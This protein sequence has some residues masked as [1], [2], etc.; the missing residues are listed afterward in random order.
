MQGCGELMQVVASIDAVGG[1][2]RCGGGSVD[3][4]VGA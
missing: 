4:G 1:E 2:R 3:A